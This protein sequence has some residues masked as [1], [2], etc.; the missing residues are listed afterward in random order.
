MSRDA[1]VSKYGQR[2]RSP[3]AHV[4]EQVNQTRELAG[5]APLVHLP[6]FDG[7]WLQSMNAREYGRLTGALRSGD[8]DSV[9]ELQAQAIASCVTNESGS[10]LWAPEAKED[11]GELLG[12][13]HAFTGVLYKLIDWFADN[14]AE[15]VEDL[16]GN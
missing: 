8:V 15:S 2:R 7:L 12:L 1:I 10:R 4:L 5:L 16:V 6:E 14:T 3:V 13:D 9:E 11:I